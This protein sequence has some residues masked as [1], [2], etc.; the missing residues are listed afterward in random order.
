MRELDEL[1]LKYLENDFP[2]GSD[3]TKDA[4]CEILALSDP[5]LRAY[6]L[7]GEDT[8]KSAMDD[9]IKKMRH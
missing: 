1:L 5:E 7:G 6:L 2:Q 9:I 8:G 3:D 4:F